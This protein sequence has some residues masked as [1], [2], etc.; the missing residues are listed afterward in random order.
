[1]KK[2]LLD[3]INKTSDAVRQ[4]G[5]VLGRL[6]LASGQKI[7]EIGCGLGYLARGIAR[8]T[9]PTG[10]VAAI[11]I[12]PAIIRAARERSEGE[13]ISYQVGDARRLPFRDG[14]FDAAV[15]VQVIEY[16]PQVDRALQEAYRV[17]APRGRFVVVATDWDAVVWH[18]GPAETMGQVARSWRTHC[19]D[20][21]LPRS[22]TGRLRAAGFEVDAV[23]VIPLL[24]SRLT[25]DSFAFGLVE[26]MSEFVRKR[27]GVCDEI[28]HRWQ[29]EL[30][31]A[32]REG[33]FLLLVNR[34]VFVAS[35]SDRN[36]Q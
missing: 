34:F 24:N 26:V 25:E 23:A 10:F 6:E 31:A 2:T 32:D 20:P 16:L 15:T 28:A 19:H 17:I 3:S 35:K 5:E 4:R 21:R 1:M 14:C 9:A 36:P 29:E 18:E 33:R 22:M 11:D 12:D 13:Q 8:R 30:H 27:R 7:L